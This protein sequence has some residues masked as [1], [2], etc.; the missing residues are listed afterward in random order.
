M[1]PVFEG[2]SELLGEPDPLVE[3][4]NGQQPGVTERGEEESSTSTVREGKKSNDNRGTNCKFIV[5]PTLT[6]NMNTH[7]ALYVYWG[8]SLAL[9][10]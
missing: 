10:E 1:P 3:L 9:F 8:P 7:N 2:S 6:C 4:A 5:A